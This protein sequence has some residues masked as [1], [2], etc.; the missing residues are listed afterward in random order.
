MG[1]LA[2]F[3]KMQL[4]I[5]YAVIISIVFAFSSTGKANDTKFI[6]PI[7]KAVVSASKIRVIGKSGDSRD[8]S[9]SVENSAGKRKYELIYADNYFYLEV[10]LRRGKNTIT[11]STP[12]GTTDSMEI[13]LADNDPE[14][15]YP[16]DFLP[17][18][19]HSKEDLTGQCNLCHP[20]DQ[21]GITQYEEVDQRLTC[22]TGD[23]HPKFRDGRFLHGPLKEEGSCIK[24]HNP[25]GSENRNFLKYF[26]GDLCYS[27]HTDAERMIGGIEYIHYP[28]KKGECT[29]CH[30]PHKSD[31]EYHLK[32]KTIDGLCAGC[33]GD[34]MAR[35]K[36]LH[37]PVKSGDCT[38]CHMPHVSKHKGLL[39]DSGS[40]LCVKCH[41]VREE[42]FNNKYI[43]GPVKKNCYIC[44]DPH[45]SPSIYHLRTRK[46][47][48]G[49][50]IPA[51]KPLQELCLGCHRKLD[52]EIA[53]QI[54]KGKVTH[55]P[56]VKDKCTV[57]HTPHST[58]YRKQLRAPLDK[59]CYSC[60]KKMEEL[61]TGS[62][63]KHGPVRINECAQ[64]HLPH[65]SENRKLLRSQLSE[66][67]TNTFKMENFSLCFNCHN[68]EMV[69]R[70]NS[71]ITGFRNGRENLHYVHVNRKKKSRNCQ[72]C[73]DI[74]ASDQEK[75]IREKIPYEG[76]ITITM[77]FTKKETGGDC[78]TGCHK[79]KKY[80]RKK[81]IKNK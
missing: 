79:P 47:E 70:K 46:D 10:Q 37:T 55:D 44:H 69:L 80:D 4:F 78:V 29:A 52:P 11:L 12:S 19:L 18:Y 50:Y 56:V 25:H 21:D 26:G 57:C 59:I 3:N 75:L 51:E 54:E 27:C 23:C 28:V 60:H 76:S 39:A 1:I 34:V 61:I 36:Y 81:S 43:H 8:F 64:C 35:E 65:G 41:K 13:I 62:L 66:E 72:T 2:R 38:A 77:E 63:Y 9:L 74:H 67:F 7:D 48:D 73:H 68:P 58:N 32:R 24:C 14:P 15:S 6:Y 40:A 49:N 20:G 31:L 22:I 45:G 33:H 5:K 71:R 42:E 30:E 17:Y 53:D 16:E